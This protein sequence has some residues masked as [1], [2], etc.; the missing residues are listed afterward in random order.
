MHVLGPDVPDHYPA[1]GTYTFTWSVTHGPCTA[2]DAVTLTFLDPADP[3]W[4]DAGPDQDFDIYLSTTLNGSVAPGTTVTW[5]VLSGTALFGDGSSATTEVTDLALGDNLLLLTASFGTCRHVTD[6]VLVHVNDVFVPQGFSPNG[7]GVN[8]LF[9]VTGAMVFPNSSLQ[10]FDRWGVEV[11]RSAPYRNEW[12]GR[13]RGNV[14][15]PD[16]TYFYTLE[17]TPGRQYKGFVVIKR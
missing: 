15:L 1:S 16:G 7:D 5:S 12:D 17:L 11:Y 10:L 8:D 13:G 4:A 14:A 3:L 9:E 6:T 2:T